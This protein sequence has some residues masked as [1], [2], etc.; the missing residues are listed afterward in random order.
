MALEE[1]LERYKKISVSKKEKNARRISIE[2]V[3]RPD[4]KDDGY[5]VEVTPKDKNS[6]PGEPHKSGSGWTEPIK[7]VFSNEKETLAYLKEVL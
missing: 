2:C 7:R 1:A 3:E 4:G 6:K 5:I